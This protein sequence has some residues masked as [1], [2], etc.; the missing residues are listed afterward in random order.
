MTIFDLLVAGGCPDKGCSGFLPDLAGAT[1]VGLDGG[2]RHL[3]LLT[4]EQWRLEAKGGHERRH[5][6]GGT[7]LGVVGVF[8]ARQVGEP[9]CWEAL[10]GTSK[11]G[12]QALVFPLSLAVSLW[13]ITR[14]YT[15]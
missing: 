9:G 14:R 7:D 5:P 11:G 6:G 3:S 1:K 10:S 8:Y 4:G 13:M 15:G 12:L 2:Y